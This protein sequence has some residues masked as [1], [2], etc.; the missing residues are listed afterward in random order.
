[1]II[2]AESGKADSKVTIK[3]KPQSTRPEKPGTSGKITSQ[4]FF[5]TSMDTSLPTL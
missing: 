1:L 5:L 4:I 3:E 2:F